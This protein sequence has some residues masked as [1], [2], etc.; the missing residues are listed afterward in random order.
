VSPGLLHIAGCCCGVSGPPV[1]LCMK[2]VMGSWKPQAGSY[3]DDGWYFDIPTGAL[4]Y[5]NDYSTGRIC[6]N[7]AGLWCVAYT[8]YYGDLQYTVR[9]ESSDWTETTIASG[10]S[11]FTFTIRDMGMHGNKVAVAVNRLTSYPWYKGVVYEYDG[12]SWTSTDVTGSNMAVDIRLA[13]DTSGNLHVSTWG[14]TDGHE[15]DG[16]NIGFSSYNSRLV[17]TPDDDVYLFT[18]ESETL[19]AY[20]STGGA[21]SWL[22]TGISSI[23]YGIRPDVAVDADGAFHVVTGD[24]KD[25]SPLLSYHTNVSGSWV[26]SSVTSTYYSQR[27]VWNIG[28]NRDNVVYIACDDYGYSDYVLFTLIDGSWV[29]SRAIGSE[30][31]LQNMAIPGGYGYSQ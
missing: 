9:N 29:K 14:S 20:Y 25:I 7:S 8:D 28:L 15:Y 6:V 11:Y 2:N 1:L 23:G 13:Y 31:T 30:E 3:D 4:A 22:D 21:W 26:P 5:D 10:S 24:Y 27:E 18:I 16:T 12:S 19:Q 17:I